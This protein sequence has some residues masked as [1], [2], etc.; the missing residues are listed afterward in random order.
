MFFHRSP[1]AN[2]LSRP[3]VA[4]SSSLASPALSQ[5]ALFS[6]LWKWGGGRGGKEGG[7]VGLKKVDNGGGI[8]VDEGGAL[9]GHDVQIGT[10]MRCY[11]VEDVICCG[12]GTGGGGEC[13][14]FIRGW[15]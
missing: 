4:H 2:S 13:S 6:V 12:G 11:S 8:C 10:V 9:F 15:G 3:L 1:N 7:E 5:V 14:Y